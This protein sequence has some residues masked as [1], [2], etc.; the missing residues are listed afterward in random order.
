MPWQIS[1]VASHAQSLRV[2]TGLSWGMLRDECGLMWALRRNLQD[3]ACRWR[4]FLSYADGSLR[5][6][7]VETSC[8]EFAALVRFTEQH[9]N[10]SLEAWAALPPASRR[11]LVPDCPVQV[12]TALQPEQAA[13]WSPFTAIIGLQEF[14]VQV[15]SMPVA[16]EDEGLWHELCQSLP[17]F[18]QI[19]RKPWGRETCLSVKQEPEV[20]D[21][22]IK[23]EVPE[24][25]DR[26]ADEPTTPRRK[27]PCIDIDASSP[28]VSKAPA[29]SRMS[30]NPKPEVPVKTVKREAAN[31]LESKSPARNR[32]VS[33]GLSGD[34]VE[35]LL[36]RNVKPEPF[37]K[38]MM[39]YDQVLKLCCRV[40]KMHYEAAWPREVAVIVGGAEEQRRSLQWQWHAHTMVGIVYSDQHWSFLAINRSSATASAVYYDGLAGAH[41]QICL[42]MALAL[43]RHAQEVGWLVSEVD[44]IREARCPVQPD[45]WSCGHRVG[46]LMSYVLEEVRAG[47]PLPHVVPDAVC[48]PE[49][50]EFLLKRSRASTQKSSSQAEMSVPPP[51][52]APAEA[53]A[54]APATPARKRPLQEVQ[55]SPAAS[56][57]SSPRVGAASSARKQRRPITKEKQKVAERAKDRARAL[58]LL[59]EAAIDHTVFQREHAQMKA[60]AEAGHWSAF[61]GSVADMSRILNCVACCEL[62]QR[63]R[64]ESA[65][66]R[67]SAKPQ[68]SDDPELLPIQDLINTTEP[69]GKGQRQH[70]KPKQSEQDIHRYIRAHRRGIYTLT[71]ASY[72]GKATY[73]CIPCS[74]K[75]NFWSQV[76]LSKLK[77]PNGHEHSSRHQR[78]LAAMRNRE[79]DCQEPEHSEAP[80]DPVPVQ[81]EPRRCKGIPIDEAPND[82]LADSFRKFVHYGQPRTV[83]KE[84]EKDPLGQI[85][86]IMD[87]DVIRL[88]SESCLGEKTE[89]PTCKNCRRACVLPSFRLHIA[90]KSMFIDLVVYVWKLFHQEQQHAVAMATQMRRADYRQLELAG[91][92]LEE[93][94]GGN[95]CKLEAARTILHK[96]VCVP[97]HRRSESMQKFL[98]NFLVEPHLYHSS[99][100]EAMAHGALA[101][102]LASSV[103]SGTVMQQDLQLAAK[104]ASGALRQDSLI[105]SLT[106]SFLF[107]CQEGAM[108]QGQRVRR[109]STRHVDMDAL[110]DAL[111]TLGKSAQ[112]L[113][114]MQRFKVNT[115]NLPKA[116]LESTSLPNPFVSLRT[117]LELRGTIRSCLSLLRLSQGRCHVLIDETVWAR[118]F[119]QVSGLR[120]T[121]TGVKETAFVGGFWQES[122]DWS[123]L[124]TRE[125]TATDLAKDSRAR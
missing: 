34:E 87:G 123:Y 111:C 103:A 90:K 100:E 28:C 13:R 113:E 50:I 4:R 115:K 79:I 112:V 1:A 107:V 116:P 19:D 5:D 51:M 74:K 78:G 122:E 24:A 66:S 48:A 45:P 110:Q 83:F 95:R 35:L 82:D 65:E 17:G 62:R 29:R 52:P 124:P 68:P 86:F 14:G 73:W 101:S 58:K 8:A 63:V 53:P 61:L 16:A 39:S 121:E 23:R 75:V 36:L 72:T 56:D 97:R 109:T 64:K 2:V 119:E 10:C 47:R 89:A 108:Q 120:N 6:Y 25:A 77:G 93:L 32:R 106:A 67:H 98:G 85:T 38:T 54:E 12:L 84:S 94:I 60:K 31:A 33:L 7:C 46:L 81:E 9:P 76:C 59:Q 44:E 27:R 92:D 11:P 80:G 15:S 105:Q 22:K 102:T 41:R 49:E 69:A 99:N 42:D 88:Q 20:F 3:D 70:S 91:G 30:R 21:T 26:E 118:A 40:A 71:D 57:V 37:D 125:Y 114:V 96:V 117:E 43:L 104:V 18:P 55:R